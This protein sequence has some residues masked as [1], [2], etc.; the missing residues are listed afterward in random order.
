MK[1]ETT[2]IAINKHKSDFLVLIIQSFKSNEA[3]YIFFEQKVKPQASQFSCKNGFGNFLYIIF[4]ILSDVSLDI[5][6]NE[7]RNHKKLDTISLLA[8]SFLFILS[9]AA[10]NILSNE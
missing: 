10:L 9:D 8:K 4:F 1:S 2:N 5:L 6:L 7:W 3:I